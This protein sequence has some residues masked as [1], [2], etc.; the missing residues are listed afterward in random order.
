MTVNEKEGDDFFVCRFK[1]WK[2][3][4]GGRTRFNGVNPHRRSPSMTVLIYVVSLLLKTKTKI[5]FF[6]REE[7]STSM[8][9]KIELE[10]F[11]M[12]I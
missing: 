4:T 1:G 7:I 12:Y 3:H 6:F 10:I 9:R 11:D 8:I 2:N 5:E